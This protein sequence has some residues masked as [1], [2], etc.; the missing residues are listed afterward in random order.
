[1]I[2]EEWGQ[3]VYGS[4]VENFVP[5]RWMIFISSLFVPNRSACCSK[6]V[7]EILEKYRYVQ[8][9]KALQHIKIK[10]TVQ[11]SV[12]KT[13]SWQSY[14]ALTGIQYGQRNEISGLDC[15][16]I[17]HKASSV[18][19][20]RYWRNW[21]SPVRN[22]GL[23]NGNGVLFISLRDRVNVTQD[24]TMVP[25]RP[26]ASPIPSHLTRPQTAH[27]LT[28]SKVLEDISRP[29]RVRRTC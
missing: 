15:T 10:T 29:S 26:S 5:S 11:A 4:L 28:M 23:L 9:R 6:H 1:M 13:Y 17:S 19:V 21:D 25:Q 27:V 20:I 7:H 18:S 2:P 14:R 16:E 3:I 22:Y 12:F 8:D 24:V